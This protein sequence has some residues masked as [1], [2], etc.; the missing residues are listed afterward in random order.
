MFNFRLIPMLSRLKYAPIQLPVGVNT[1]TE[2]R[3][4]LSLGRLANAGVH[5]AK[6]HHWSYRNINLMTFGVIGR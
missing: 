1:V 3:I 2:V 6:T 4:S 5:D